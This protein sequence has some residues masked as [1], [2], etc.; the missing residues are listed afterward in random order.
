LY[1]ATSAIQAQVSVGVN[2]GLPSIV[3]S[4]QYERGYEPQRRKVVYREVPV[5]YENHR[6]GRC[7]DVRRYKTRRYGKE[8]S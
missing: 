2:I 4:G 7:C 5:V 6:H 8:T 3:I 1:F